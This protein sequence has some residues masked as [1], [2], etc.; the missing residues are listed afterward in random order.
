MTEIAV[1]ILC[2]I[3]VAIL[4]VVAILFF[5]HGPIL[6]KQAR[7]DVAG[8]G[9]MLHYADDVIALMNATPRSGR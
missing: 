9:R 1:G 2:G 6:P 7:S 4:I 3:P 8:F 5:R